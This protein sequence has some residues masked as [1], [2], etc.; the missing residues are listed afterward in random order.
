MEGSGR[1][2]AS[3]ASVRRNRRAIVAR[4]G[5]AADDVALDSWTTD[6]FNGTLCVEHGDGTGSVYLRCDDEVLE[7]DPGFEGV[8][9]PRRV[10]ELIREA[11]LGER[12]FWEAD[13]A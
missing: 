6:F 11:L 9:E 12:P 8:R 1:T 10:E 2:S 13:L 7:P 5:R 4:K 3:A